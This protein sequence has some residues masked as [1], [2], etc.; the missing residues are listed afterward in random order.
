MSHVFSIC[1][2]GS[3]LGNQLFRLVAGKVVALDR[4][5]RHEFIGTGYF[6]G[7]DFINLGD[8]DAHLPYETDSSSGKVTCKALY[9]LWEE[10]TQSYNP[11]IN[12]INPDTIIDG[13]FQDDKYFSH[14]MKEVDKWLK[15][16]PL[17]MP[18][19]LCVIGFR[20]GEFYVYSELGLPKTYFEQGI[21]MMRE[22]NP[23]MRFEVHTDDEVLAK[24]FFPDFPVVHNIGINWRSMRYAKHAIIANSSFFIL[25][26]LL[27]GGITIAP[28][29]W[30]RRNIDEWS[31]PDNFYRQFKYV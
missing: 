28:R 6:K 24:T 16:E 29:G 5:W 21:S 4:G 19:D 2:A 18:D 30:A 12:F 22:I 23:N 8:I 27:N 31:R 20:G 17:E 15:V 25:P 13:E 26:R 10:K 14:R 11:E 3:G 9:P 1:H 7:K